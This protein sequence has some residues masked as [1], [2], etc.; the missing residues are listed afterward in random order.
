M[1][2][3]S[4]APYQRSDY[5]AARITA[6]AAP[7]RSQ[8]ILDALKK[9]AQ[10]REL[11]GNRKRRRGGGGGGGGGGSSGGERDGNSSKLLP[12]KFLKF[13]SATRVAVLGCVQRLLA[14]AP[15]QRLRPTPLNCF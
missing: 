4:T 2:A 7:T 6:I 11:A 1:A 3:T 5:N 12:M 9:T 15:P 14:A 13:L 10:C 8:G